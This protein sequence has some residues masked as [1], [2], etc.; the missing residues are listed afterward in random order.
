MEQGR[1][2]LCRFFSHLH[3][4]EGE[5]LTL[6]PGTAQGSFIITRPPGTA[7]G[8]LTLCLFL[9]H[10]SQFPGHLLTH[11]PGTHPPQE[12]ASGSSTSSSS[13]DKCRAEGQQVS[14]RQLTFPPAT[15]CPIL[16]VLNPLVYTA[17]VL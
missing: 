10:I 6:S 1:F 17:P 15:T 11:P 8:G 14:M 16:Q 4:S 13:Q 3:K 5:H 12:A 2:T 9:V 7:E